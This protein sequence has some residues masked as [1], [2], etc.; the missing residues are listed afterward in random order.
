MFLKNIVSNV[1]LVSLLITFTA[2]AQAAQLNVLSDGIISAETGN[3]FSNN[4]STIINDHYGIKAGM[5]NNNQPYVLTLKSDLTTNHNYYGLYMTTN[6]RFIGMLTMKSDGGNYTYNSQYNVTRDNSGEIIHG[7]G[8]YSYRGAQAFIEGIDINASNN[9]HG[10][11]IYT[12][13]GVTITGRSDG[14]NV[15][16]ASNNTNNAR[17]LGRG[18]SAGSEKSAANIYNM[19]LILND[20]GQYGIY[21][22]MSS[23]YTG[24]VNIEGIAAGTNTLEALRNGNSGVMARGKNSDIYIKNMTINASNNGL[25]GSTATGVGAADNGILIIEG[26]AGGSNSLTVNNNKNSNQKEGVGLRSSNAGTSVKISNM[27]ITSNGNSFGIYALNGGAMEINGSAGKTNK[28]VVSGNK[29]VDEAI[30]G[31]I[32]AS[33]SQIVKVVMT[34]QADLESDTYLSDVPLD[35]EIVES[36]A[37][38]AVASSIKVRD[39]DITSSGNFHGVFASQTGKIDFKGKADGSNTLSISQ[40]G[41]SDGRNG[42]G[43]F[44]LG[45]DSMI[46]VENMDINISQNVLSGISVDNNA[47][48]SLS[49]VSNRSVLSLTDNGLNNI[50]V[51]DSSLKITNFIVDSADSD[52]MNVKNGNISFANSI[53][54][55]DQNKKT[56]VL[57]GTNTLNFNDSQYETP[58]ML[59]LTAGETTLNAANSTLKGGFN[60]A[61][62]ALLNLNLSDSHWSGGGSVK[63]NQLNNDNSVVD[64]RQNNGQ[65]TTLTTTDYQGNNGELLMNVFFSGNQAAHDSLTVTNSLTGSS[66]INLYDVGSVQHQNSKNGIRLVDARGTTLNNG[67]FSL[68]GGVFDLLDYDYQLYKGEAEG[69]DQESWFL[70]GTNKE[71]PI[72]E[73]M[74]D[75]VPLHL[76]IIKTGMNELRKRLGDIRHNKSTDTSGAWIRTYAKHLKIDDNLPFHMNL[77]GV[78]GGFDKKIWQSSGD[79]VLA[80]IMAGIVD[81]EDI[82]IKQGNGYNGK[83]HGDAPTVGAYLSWFN[84]GGWF[85]DATARYFWSNLNLTSYGANGTAVRYKP[86]HDF[87][88]FSGETGKQFIVRQDINNT[89]TLEPKAEILYAHSD[90]KDHK[91]SINVGLRYGKMET[92]TTR[93]GFKA[94]WQKKFSAQSYIGP[95]AEINFVREWLGDTDVNYAGSKF[96]SDIS[97][98]GY[99]LALGINGRF[100]DHFNYYTDITYENG[101]ITEAFA[102]NI[103][104]RYTF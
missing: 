98:N 5:N 7:A 49:G 12:G 79:I 24:F 15:L 71:T 63:L 43:L 20:N 82:K 74:T 13:G 42:S 99:E 35:T 62:G 68:K 53:L 61:D 48:I 94:G 30:N 91:T 69:D 86:D 8:I 88:A 1:W 50:N 22:E 47:E 18:I 83:G 41:K 32:Q 45:A 97:G 93:I 51:A 64:L 28:L 27:D 80:G 46:D 21:S 75:I 6:G 25:T 11:L 101:K 73:T 60:T 10:I 2:A 96:K 16:N 92:L 38:D 103:G 59:E 84:N 36:L 37:K 44:A 9:M 67:I 57:E 40:N 104:L 102:A 78:E 72:A 77:Y 17:T 33:G 85:A 23:E 66:V 4:G 54:N 95:F 65:Y 87:I 89:Y 34:P 90:A 100:K 29:R 81:T 56:I 31:G 19:N 55:V 70:R 76:H 14:S 52:F 39:M 26:V 3:D 58:V